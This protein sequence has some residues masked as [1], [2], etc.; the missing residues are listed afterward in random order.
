MLT[1]NNIINL[2]SKSYENRITFLKII[3]RCG[4][5]TLFGG[6]LS[7]MDLLT[8]LYNGVMKHDPKN[9]KWKDRDIFLLSGGHKAIGLYVVLQ[10][11]GYFSK[12]YYGH[13]INLN[14]EC[15]CI[16]M[17]IITRFGVPFRFSW[18]WIICRY[19]DCSC[20]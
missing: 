3:E 11:V 2:I 1:K 13:I 18:P 19:W 9:P 5:D 17:E 14:Q 16:L 6:V 10:S 4:G 7:S 8:V 20:L 15:P 12:I